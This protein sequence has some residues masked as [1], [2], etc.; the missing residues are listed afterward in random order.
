MRVFTLRQAA[1]L[2][3]RRPMI[4]KRDERTEAKRK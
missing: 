1:E 2:L 4:E 3:G